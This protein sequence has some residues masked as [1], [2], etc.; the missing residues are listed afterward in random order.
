MTGLR[1][2]ING[3]YMALVLKRINFRLGLFWLIS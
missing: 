1:N 2:K 3:T